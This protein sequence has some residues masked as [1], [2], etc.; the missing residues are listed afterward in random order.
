MDYYSASSEILFDV[1]F[2]EFWNKSSFSASFRILS[3]L[4]P[5]RSALQRLLFEYSDGSFD[6]QRDMGP[7]LLISYRIGGF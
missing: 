4:N 7:V 1:E 3:R 5:F 2:T 6:L